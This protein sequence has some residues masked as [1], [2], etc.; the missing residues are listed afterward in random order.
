MPAVI[1]PYRDRGVDPLRGQ[2][3]HYVLNYWGNLGFHIVVCDDGRRGDEQFNRSA[4]YNR[5]TAMTTADILIYVEADTLVP[6]DQIR[7]AISKAESRPGLVVPFTH[8]KKLSDTDS[9]LVRSGMKQPEDCVPTQHPYGETTN[10]GCANVLSR[11]TLEAVGKWDEQFDGHGHDDNA[12]YH[13]FQVVARPVRWTE[14]PAYHLCHRDM[15]PDTSPDRALLTDE[16]VAAQERN[17]RRLELYRAAKTPEEIRLLTSG[18]PTDEWLKKYWG[19][20]NW[21][22]RA[23]AS[24]HGI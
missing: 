22:I 9:M 20:L 5:G 15:D 16:D 4:A 11:K 7:E 3:L 8:Q 17:R 1:I 6:L 2:N 13:A 18:V 14:G 24:D 21:R 23:L 10:Y 12:M 19:K